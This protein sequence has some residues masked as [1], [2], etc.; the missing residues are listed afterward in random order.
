MFVLALA[1]QVAEVL[2]RLFL[3]PG[4]DA[5]FTGPNGMLAFFGSTCLTS[6]PC[7]PAFSAI[8]W[9]EIVGESVASTVS[10]TARLNERVVVQLCKCLHVLGTACNPVVV[11]DKGVGCRRGGEHS[12]MDLVNCLSLMILPGHSRISPPSGTSTRAY[13]SMFRQSW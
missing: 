7:H 1:L 10:S 5:C 4:S 2:A 9:L 8:S 3:L 6:P 12:V 11:H 13:R